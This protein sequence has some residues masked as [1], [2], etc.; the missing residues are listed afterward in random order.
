MNRK[1]RVYNRI[2]ILFAALFA[3][4][5]F[6]SLIDGMDD[7]I[8]ANA[9]KN[10]ASVEVLYAYDSF[11]AEDACSQEMIEQSH[12]INAV[13]SASRLSGRT[14]RPNIRLQLYFNVIN[15]KDILCDHFSEDK[16][17]E[18]IIVYS[19]SIAVGFIEAKDGKKA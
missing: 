12:Q 19:A 7:F 4:Y 11:D 15:D 6:A 10:S 16:K 3:V 14:A 2:L 13:I 5:S 9:L 18:M 17:G 8:A 1:I